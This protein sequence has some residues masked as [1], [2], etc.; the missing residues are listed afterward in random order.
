MAIEEWR[1]VVGFNAY[2]IN[3]RRQV[4][5][6]FTRVYLKPDAKGAVYLLR[7]GVRCHR[8]VEKLYREAFEDRQGPVLDVLGFRAIPGFPGYSI[9]REGDVYNETRKIFLTHNKKW[10]SV[11]L[12]LDGKQVRKT[13]R[14]LLLLTYGR[15]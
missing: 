10:D 8:S 3:R 14:G 4:Q 11:V 6:R 1:P 9:N 2:Q 15:D 13:V 12:V 7:N 5:N